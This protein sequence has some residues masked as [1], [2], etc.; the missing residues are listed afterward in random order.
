MSNPSSA[1]ASRRIPEEL[2]CSRKSQNGADL[3][4]DK[5]YGGREAF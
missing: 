4:F 1:A 3:F 2:S 5:R